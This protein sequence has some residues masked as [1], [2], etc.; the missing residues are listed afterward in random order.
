MKSQEQEGILPAL[1]QNSKEVS[2]QHKP[3][4]ITFAD[5]PVL[6]FIWFNFK[7]NTKVETS[8]IIVLQWKQT[9]G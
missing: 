6:I 5:Q 4:R 1:F 9:L 3:Q 8:F 2:P 7:V